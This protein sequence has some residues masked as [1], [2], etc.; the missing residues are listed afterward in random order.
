M[1]YKTYKFIPLVFP[2][3]IRSMWPLLLG[4]RVPKDDEVT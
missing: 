2:L 4:M 1:R 3:N